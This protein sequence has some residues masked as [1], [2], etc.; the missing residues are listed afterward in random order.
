MLFCC[1]FFYKRDDALQQVNDL[2]CQKEDLLINTVNLEELHSKAKL[3]MM[4]SEEQL[5][6]LENKI[7]N[8]DITL[9]NQVDNSYS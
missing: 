5:R 4:G 2:K 3:K 8:G 7:S 6:K 1:L 9:A